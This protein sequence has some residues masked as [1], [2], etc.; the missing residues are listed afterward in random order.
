MTELN[1]DEFKSIA[2]ESIK[3]NDIQKQISECFSILDDGNKG[4]ISNN[5]IKLLMTK[6]GDPL[7]DE[8]I[9]QVIS[10]IT[11]NNDDKISLAQFVSCINKDIKT[12]SI[13][14]NKK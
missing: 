2:Q 3:N 6:L 14:M 12:T 10:I 7:T 5:D 8:E 11:D 9:N 4:H 1:Y 13:S